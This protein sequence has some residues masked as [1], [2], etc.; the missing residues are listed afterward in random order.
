MIVAAFV[1]SFAFVLDVWQWL[2]PLS[3][4]SIILQ[5]AAVLA[6]LYSLSVPL[7]LNHFSA[8]INHLPL[9]RRR[10]FLLPG[11]I[12]LSYL[13]SSWLVLEFNPSDA[14]I[15][16]VIGILVHNALIDL[17]MQGF[18]HF[19][20]T[21]AS[22]VLLVYLPIS[23]YWTF[24]INPTTPLTLVSNM[25]YLSY[26]WWSLVISCYLVVG[27]SVIRP[28]IN[29]GYSLIPMKRD[30]LLLAI[31]ILLLCITSLPILLLTDLFESPNEFKITILSS[32]I[33]D[34][35]SVAIPE[36]IFF[37]GIMISVS[38]KL[39]QR[40]SISLVLSSTI[41]LLVFFPKGQTLLYQLFYSLYLFSVG[42]LLGF[43]YQKSGNRLFCSILLH[44][45]LNWFLLNFI[46]IKHVHTIYPNNNSEGIILQD[47]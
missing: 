30:F 21:D 24:V 10:T 9:S 16:F 6:L 45:F 34:L 3:R 8:F 43:I 25:Q 11:I 27:Y 2:A 7:L 46:S 5:F 26:K 37:R 19:T 44:S 18:T 39:I 31:S 33:R 15:I 41:Y 13:L 1:S 22:I 47:T 42:L 29:V 23:I 17:Q 4:A 36:E 35:T 38:E 12:S 20:F 28:I 32:W 40:Q 14:L